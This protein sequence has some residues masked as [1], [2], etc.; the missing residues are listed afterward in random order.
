[1]V[2]VVVVAALILKRAIACGGPRGEA[3]WW[4]RFKGSALVGRKRK[5]W[6]RT[7]GGTMIASSKTSRFCR[8]TEWPVQL[9]EGA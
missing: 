4:V 5:Y 6:M 2:V 8:L 7:G 9:E 3:K 1:M